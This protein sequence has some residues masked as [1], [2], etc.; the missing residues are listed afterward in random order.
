MEKINRI[1]GNLQAN[2]DGLSSYIENNTNVSGSITFGIAEACTLRCYMES[3]EKNIKELKNSVIEL[4]KVQNYNQAATEYKEPE[5]RKIEGK[6]PQSNRVKHPS[7][8]TWLKNKCGI[9][10]IDITRHLNF[11]IG[12]VVK[13]VLRSGHKSEK[14]MS[15]K[16][17]QIEDL[18]KAAFYINDEIER[19]R[20]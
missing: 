13:Y 10:V 8:Y 9:E 20:K 17:K 4:E 7:H 16:Q 1:T 18:Q 14:G 2:L 11:N 12:N 6:V 19:L 5:N 3:L 15:D